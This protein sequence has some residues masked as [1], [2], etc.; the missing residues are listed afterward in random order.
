M[1]GDSLAVMAGFKPRASTRMAQAWM[2]VSVP[3][4]AVLA[5][6]PDSEPVVWV[7]LTP[8]GDFSELELGVLGVLGLLLVPVAEVE[9]LLLVKPEPD[10]ELPEGLETGVPPPALVDVLEPPPAKP[11]PGMLELPLLEP[12]TPESLPLE[13]PGA[14]PATPV[15]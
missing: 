2:V 10:V 13:L 8:S 4:V 6:L 7:G 5:G 15:T 1:A 14:E 3:E 12:V 11:C 9:G